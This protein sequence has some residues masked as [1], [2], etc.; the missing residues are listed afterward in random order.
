LDVVSLIRSVPKR[1]T[2]FAE[3]AT[4][5]FLDRRFEIIYQAVFA[6]FCAGLLAYLIL[7]RYKRFLDDYSEI[8]RA[9]FIFAYI[10]FFTL[11]TI[12][13]RSIMGIIPLKAAHLRSSL[14]Y[15]ATWVGAGLGTVFVIVVAVIANESAIPCF[16]SSYSLGDWAD[17]LAI[18]ILAI[19]L[20]ASVHSIQSKARHDLRLAQPDDD[21]IANVGLSQ[22]AGDPLALLAWIEQEAPIVNRRQDLLGGYPIARRLAK[23]LRSPVGQDVSIGLCGAYGSGK[24][25]IIQMLER[26]LAKPAAR[27]S[28]NVWL[29][30]VSCWGFSD[31]KAALQSVLEEALRTIDVHIDT[32]SL[33]RLP[34]AYREAVSS[35]VEL[36]SRLI[37]RLLDGPND[38]DGQLRRLS[39]LLSAAG[40]RLVIVIEDLERNASNE[41]DPQHIQAMLQRFKSIQGVSFV[42]VGRPR[43]ADKRFDY[44]KLCDHIENIPRVGQGVVREIIETLREH[45]LDEYTD[46]DPAANRYRP[47]RADIAERIAFAI[48]NTDIPWKSITDLVRTPRALKHILRDT[49]KAWSMLHGEI[50][51]DDLLMLNMMRCCSEEGYDFIVDRIDALR[52]RSSEKTHY[53]RRRET[54]DKKE[55]ATRIEEQWAEW[56]KGV[57]WDVEAGFGLLT[58]LLPPEGYSGVHR[59]VPQGVRN[60][61]PTNYFYRYQAGEIDENTVLDQSVLREIEKWRIAPPPVSDI[62]AHSIYCSEQYAAIWEHYSSRIPSDHLVSLADEIVREILDDAG[63]DAEGDHHSLITVWRQLLRLPHTTGLVETWLQD[64]VS[65]VIPRSLRF[66]NDLFYFWTAT[67]K[68]LITLEGAAQVRLRAVESIRSSFKFKA[69]SEFTKA[70]SKKDNVTIYQLFYPPNP[71]DSDNPRPSLIDSQDREW[72]IPLILSSADLDPDLIVPQLFAIAFQEDRS[73]DF[74]YVTKRRETVPRYSIEEKRLSSVF[75]EYSSEV[76]KLIAE[77]AVPLPTR[78]AEQNVLVK[79][80]ARR[81]AMEHEPIAEKTERQS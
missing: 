39:P 57:D 71:D 75:G 60:L 40:A 36:W 22:I 70:I 51:L 77:P 74:D 72:F 68:G 42:L 65:D 56:T 29:C 30:K 78:D 25:S 63:A 54:E 10:V 50:D 80:Q 31:S 48:V 79:E 47:I 32:A 81:W 35:G 26:E 13:I 17:S 58:F 15:P 41:F 20:A 9:Q 76:M 5:T 62:M 38:P 66:F 18:F 8:F 6:V 7:P 28:P 2:Y 24:S 33:I 3:R 27:N 73:R 45:W 69:P 59:H 61:Y 52:A 4:K 1:W 19:V 37:L 21:T 12:I 53:P 46:I 55:F 16:L 23:L 49:N 43:V 34:E 64:K 11:T 44:Q 67:G 14:R